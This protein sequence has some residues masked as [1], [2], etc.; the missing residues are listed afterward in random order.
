MASSSVY[1]TIST[2][3]QSGYRQQ[4]ISYRNSSN[5]FRPYR[6]V[7][8]YPKIHSCGFLAQIACHILSLI[9]HQRAIPTHRSVATFREST[10]WHHFARLRY[11]IRTRSRVSHHRSPNIIFHSNYVSLFHSYYPDAELLLWSACANSFAGASCQGWW[12]HPTS[13]APA[14]RCETRKAR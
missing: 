14:Y 13:E 8:F 3:K 9:P 6:K 7:C 4:S 5:S 1:V 2:T 11:S 12:D 10:R